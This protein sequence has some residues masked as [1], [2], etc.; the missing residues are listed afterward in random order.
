MKLSEAIKIG[1]KKRRQA[2]GLFFDETTSGEIL[3]DV[4]GAAF[5][6]AGIVDVADLDT[7][8]PPKR[9]NELLKPFD[10]LAGVEAPCPVGVCGDVAFDGKSMAVHRIAIHLNDHHCWSREGI[11]AWL[12]KYGC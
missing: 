12:E 2:R 3:S 11:A 4:L 7:Y 1:A 5:E 9:L 6:G 8:M 10:G